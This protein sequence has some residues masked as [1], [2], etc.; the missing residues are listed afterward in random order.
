MTG[1]RGKGYPA[2]LEEW[3]VIHEQISVRSLME[4]V[5]RSGDLDRT[6]SGARDPELMVIGTR[7][8]Q[9]YQQAQ[10]A[11]YQSEVRLS[12][13]VSFGETRVE[14][15]STE[16]GSACSYFLPVRADLPDGE[17]QAVPVAAELQ[18]DGRA[19][20]IALEDGRPVIE[21]IK[22][23]D[24]DVRK[25][26]EAIP[27]HLAQAKGYA[28]LYARD[29]G[30]DDIAVRM[31]YIPM[32]EELDGIVTFDYHY[33]F[34]ELEAWF[35]E[36]VL[37]YGKW[38]LFRGHHVE[39]RTETLKELT[40]PYAYREGQKKLIEDVYR[41]IL[42]EKKLFLEA[43]TGVGKTLATLYPTVK[44][45]GEG[46]TDKVFYLTAKTITRTVA[47][48][49]VGILQENG[50][51]ISSVTIT[52][53]ERS[54]ILGHAD[55][56]PEKCPR[57]KG[58]L[59]RVND[60]VFD[61][62]IHES[63][64]TRQVV[65]HYA[66]KHQVCPFEFCLDISLLT[67]IVICDYNYAF[68]PNAHLRRFFE[69]VRDQYVFLIDEAHNLVERAKEMYS[70]EIAE[71]TLKTAKQI[72]AGPKKKAAGNAGKKSRKKKK[73]D[74]QLS[75]FSM[76][77]DQP[78][79]TVLPPVEEP[80]EEDHA[81]AWQP[82]RLEKGIRD[83]V[84]ALLA[85]LKT[86]KEETAGGEITIVG[87]VPD[88]VSGAVERTLRAFER[89]FAEENQRFNQMKG[90]EDLLSVYFMLRD[91]Q[92]IEETLD[93]HYLILS[94]RT[95]EKN[96]R[97]AL[98]CMNPRSQLQERY[99]PVR[100]VILFSAT[101]LP[102]E[103]Y[104]EELGAEEED[105]AVYAPSP[106]PKENRRILIAKDVTTRYQKRGKNM[107]ARIAAYIAEMACGK[108]GNYIAFFP[109]YAFLRAVQEELE[110]TL[111]EAFL[112]GDVRVLVQTAE[113]SEQEKE[114]FLAAFAEEPVVTTI[115]LAVMGGIFSEGIDL[116]ADRLIGAAIV[117]PGLPMVTK[118]RE[119]IRRYY[120]ERNGQGFDYAY[121]YLGMNKVLQ[122][123]G[124]VIRT[125]EDRGVILLLDDRFLWQDYRKLFP[126]EW[127]PHEQI[128]LENLS[129]E[130]EDF[131]SG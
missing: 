93:G 130:L 116:A 76:M 64:I 9:K 61:L 82:S 111:A 56:N 97:F 23:M 119:L 34:T 19:D 108:C 17:Q 98:S 127:Y 6:Q 49:A 112:P 33:S 30:L 65:D 28:Y 125:A 115:G 46:L 102:I 78:E 43:P 83:A 53:R 38:V 73:E 85:A 32:E 67:D 95:D 57:A 27:V 11:A 59:D 16:E 12:L 7:L 4:F 69:S 107:Y 35:Y 63:R 22:S 39:G 36:I 5:L 52:S 2:A 58:H 109:S 8:H 118:E 86:V 99:A 114:V 120:E 89:M 79:I 101:L 106:F 84:T 66:E 96:Y 31:V 87:A 47:E 60:A 103:Y 10:D 13:S 42:R 104:R 110:T 77:P 41:T 3:T 37:S 75:L 29:H 74:D 70:A 100:S 15:G 62:I 129:R 128:T 124:R 50:A 105:Y 117:G 1:S 44:A 48:D 121:L 123:G 54:C 25:L 92:N 55:C 21:E 126:Q 18:I 90:H 40:F 81:D 68:D 26:K 51:G 91:F 14:T 80:A 122:A 88:A 94:K 71:E 113:M 24:M 72:L 20:G 45:M 131:W